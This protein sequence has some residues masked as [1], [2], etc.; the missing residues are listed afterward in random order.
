MVIQILKCNI[1]YD[2]TSYLQ[3][4]FRATIFVSEVQLEY[5]GSRLNDSE[6]ISI[7]IDIQ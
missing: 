2:R 5:I 3:T 6:G 1:L 4:K 7:A